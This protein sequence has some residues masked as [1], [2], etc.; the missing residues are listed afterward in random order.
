[1]SAR[2]Q[3]QYL[4][5]MGGPDDAHCARKPRDLPKYARRK[6]EPDNRQAQLQLLLQSIAAPPIS[7]NPSA[8]P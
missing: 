5:G 3:G 2:S 6:T 4:F 1:M 7:A 8:H